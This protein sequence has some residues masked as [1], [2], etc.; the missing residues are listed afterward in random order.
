[1]AGDGGRLGCPP[2]DGIDTAEHLAEHLGAVL[3]R[4]SAIVCVGNDLCGD[5]GAGVAIAR[6]LAG[7]VPWTVHDTGTVP[8]SFLMK[9]VDARPQSVLLID[10]LDFGA[11]PGATEQVESSRAT[12]QSQRAGSEAR[13][14]QE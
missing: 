14:P 5:D 1:M 9:I 12:T 8:E 11:S 4:D 13:W 6:R 10:S 7:A 3:C 2:H